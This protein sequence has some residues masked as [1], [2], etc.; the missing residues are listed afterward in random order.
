MWFKGVVLDKIRPSFHSQLRG[1]L[2]EF[3]SIETWQASELCGRKVSEA[4]VLW[5]KSEFVNFVYSNVR[6]LRYS[7]NI[8]K[9]VDKIRSKII[10]RIFLCEVSKNEVHSF[11]AR[12]KLTWSCG[13]SERLWR[14]EL[15]IYMTYS[16][17]CRSL[18]YKG[19]NFSE[20]WTSSV[21]NWN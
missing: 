20:H 1:K 18:T 2:Y 5:V 13:R 21:V 4:E 15:I 17:L 12:F 9:R 19:D 10:F 6:W 8:L 16:T 3:T 11:N 14:V 7:D